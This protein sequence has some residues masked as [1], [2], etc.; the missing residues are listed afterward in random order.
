[1]TAA[2]VHAAIA[3]VLNEAVK[4]VRPIRRCDD[5]EVV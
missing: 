2:E 1:M 3:R 5:D 4:Q